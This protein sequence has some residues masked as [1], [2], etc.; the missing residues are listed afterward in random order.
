MKLEMHITNI[1]FK[2]DGWQC[3]VGNTG[4]EIPGVEI[5]C[6]KYQAGINELEILRWNVWA[7]NNGL[8][9]AGSK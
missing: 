4:L 3:W 9:V 5:Q 2:I 6:W 8:E 7:G 1:G